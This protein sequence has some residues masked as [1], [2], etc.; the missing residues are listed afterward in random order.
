MEEVCTESLK[1]TKTKVIGIKA[2][3]EWI[4]TEI[5]LYKRDKRSR[6][7][8]KVAKGDQNRN[9]LFLFLNLILFPNGFFSMPS[10]S[11]L[12]ITVFGLSAPLV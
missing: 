3:R 8:R 2:K 12:P 6:C 10:I 5:L 11:T 4:D 1:Y 9:R 7:L